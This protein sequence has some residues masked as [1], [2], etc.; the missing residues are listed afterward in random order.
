MSSV[1]NLLQA[2]VRT[3][4]KRRG[5]SEK[6]V[7]SLVVLPAAL[8]ALAMFVLYFVIIPNFPGIHQYY[9]PESTHTYVTYRFAILGH[10]LFGTIAL[11]LGPINLYNALRG[12]HFGIH[13]KIGT[14]YAAALSASAPCAMFM[15]FHAY[16]GNHVPHGQL[17]ITSG[18][19]I[20]AWLWLIT[21]YLAL[22]N[23]IVK[24]NKNRHF[25]WMIINI[26][27]TF[28]AVVFRIE[29]GVVVALN[30]FEAF[31]PYLG[32]LSWVPCAIVGVVLATRRYNRAVATTKPV[33]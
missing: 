20:L 28:A 4:N 9:F 1:D 10:I 5:Q 15:A 24:H 18:L 26:S 12:K 14:A 25:F 13:R 32:W 8:V 23:I 2:R 3:E 6:L 11:F 17:I 30:K 16:G 31:Y 29:N 33:A 22:Y 27:L 19:F 21:L 7:L